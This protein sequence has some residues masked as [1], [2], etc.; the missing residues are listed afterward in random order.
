MQSGI[1]LFGG[2]F[3]PVHIGHLFIV[4]EVRYALG[5]ER[6]FFVPAYQ[7]PHKNEAPQASTKER[8]AM[9][10]CALRERPGCSVLDWEINRGGRSYTIDTVERALEQYPGMAKPKLI[11]GDD[12]CADFGSWHQAERLLQLVELVIV[13]RGGS[14][15]SDIIKE[16]N[17]VD[18]SP[19]PVS[20]SDIR[21]RIA[22][23]RNY[24]DLVP[25]AVYHYIE[26]NGLYRSSLAKE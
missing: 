22:A 4:E 16:Y 24:R 3:D 8:M 5:I 20:S 7:P 17:L 14:V 15:T 18:N 10:E 6:V 19:L 25:Q 26:E 21:E 9:L 2:S 23:G 1:A 11:I 13:T 12:L